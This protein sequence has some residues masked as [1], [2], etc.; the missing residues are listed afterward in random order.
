VSN[1]RVTRV[2]EILARHAQDRDAAST[3]IAAEQRLARTQH[4]VTM[5]AGYDQAWPALQKCHQAAAYRD[6]F[7]Q[8]HSPWRSVAS[9]QVGVNDLG[10]IVEVIPGRQ[11]R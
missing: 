10:F 4:L 6:H 11:Q 9:L 1:F 3:V 7:P 2:P 5:G 8:I